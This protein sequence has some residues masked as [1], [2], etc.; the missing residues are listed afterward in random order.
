MH[1]VKEEPSIQEICVNICGG[2]INKLLLQ[3]EIAGFETVDSS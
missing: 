1:A 2:R 3:R